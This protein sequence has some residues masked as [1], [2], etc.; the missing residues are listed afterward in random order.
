MKGTSVHFN[1]RRIK[2]LCNPKVQEFAMALR[3]QSFRDPR[4]TCLHFTLRLH[5]IP[6]LQSGVTKTQT[7]KTQTSDLR[8]RKLRPRK[9]RP[10]KLR[11]RK[12]RSRKLR[13]LEIE[14]KKKL[15]SPPLLSPELLYRHAV[16]KGNSPTSK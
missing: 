13:P 1:Y 10:R 9:L 5:F 12:L 2:Q 8:P 15:N 16:F 6:G 14:R 4:E 7:P 11:P 3:V